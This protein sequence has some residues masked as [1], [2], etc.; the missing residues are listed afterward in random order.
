MPDLPLALWIGLAGVFG[1]LFG[2]FLNV[3][4]LR[5]PARM[6]AEW[7]KQAREV[8]ELDAVDEALPPGVVKES[9]HCPK[10]KHP[11]AARDNIPLFGW[12]MLRGR[13]RYCH[14]PISIQYPLV[15]LLAG[16]ASA[17]V[18]WRFGPTPGA[19]AGLVLT[20]FLIALSGI[21]ARTQ[22]LPDELNYP[23]LWI[24]LTLCL[25]PSWQPLPIAPT[26]A[27]LAA[28]LG[29]L[30]LWSVYWLFKLLTGKEGMGHGD[31]KLLAALGAWMGPVALLPIVM[32]SSLIGAIVGGA[33][34]LFRR[35]GREVP[36]PF[37]PYLAAA[38]WVWFLVGD[39]LLALY[40]QVSGIR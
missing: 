12:V 32:L 14:E 18:V 30:S 16:L 13:C 35:H 2:S 26:S 24:G 29:Y 5:V 40:M 15:E 34:I 22:L 39:R 23:L 11:L 10:C 19:L 20:Y 27:I 17:A 33:L 28:L 6:Q 38:G 4:I 8:L 3:V 31:F 1:L 21:D 37:G 7:R 25:I 9:S 36:I